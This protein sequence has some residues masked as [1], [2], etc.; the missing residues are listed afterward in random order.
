MHIRGVWPGVGLVC[1]LLLPPVALAQWQID[2]V[3]PAENFYRPLEPYVLA[4]P[5]DLPLEVLR[6][7]SLELND[8]DVTA[9]VHREGDLAIFKPPQAMAYGT[10]HLRLVESLPD[11]SIVERALWQVEVR[12]SRALREASLQGHADLTSARRPD[13]K[14]V[15][16]QLSANQRQGSMS[17]DG[18]MAND[19]WRLHATADVIHNS[20]VDQ[21]PND[22]RTDLARGLI[23]ADRGALSLR[24]GDHAIPATGLVMRDFARRGISGSV[25]NDGLRA[26][27]TAFAMR[28]ETITGFRH[29]LGAGDSANRSDG[30]MLTTQ[31]LTNRPE[32]LR[33]SAL[34]LNAEGSPVGDATAGDPES[35]RNDAAALAVDSLIFDQRLRLRGEY[36]RSD[37]DFDGA[38]TLVGDRSDKARSLLAQYQHPQR[39]LRGAVFGWNIG[40]EHSEVGP[41]F[42]SLANP[43]LPA[44]KRLDRV[45]S[46]LTWRGLS[47]N[48]QAA[49][50]TDNVDDEPLLPRLR[51]DYLTL[52]GTYTP[53]RQP[54]ETG[55]GRLFN[56]PSLAF[57]AQRMA[58]KHT[59]VPAA[60]GGH[61]VDQDTD[62]LHAGARFSPGNW[63][64]DIAH[65]RT[66]FDDT[67]GLQADYTNDLTE[68]GV[69]LLLSGRVSLSPRIQYNRF[70]DSTHGL[71]TRTLTAML[72]ASAA[73]IPGKLD[74]SLN[75]ALNRERADDDSLDND[76][77]SVDALLNWT[78][79]QPRENRP[80]LSVYASGSYFDARKAPGATPDIYQIFAGLRIGWPVAY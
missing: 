31:P 15:A 4:L 29:G 19:D 62:L 67:A 39:E 6:R 21:M 50:E 59:D 51:T 54:A 2:L 35:V 69:D 71:V 55:V 73:L 36:A 34:Y 48:A 12:Q 14:N 42:Y 27:L 52:G 72:G 63:S 45:F 33:V 74:A 80:G 57:S 23:A 11:G 47:L 56:G 26:E 43:A 68:F 10:H 38:G 66:W 53:F 8:I 41:W 49:R 16:P 32:R 30:V 22:R 60:F 79:I 76:S 40:A 17:L 9:F 1:A 46:G 78:L 65:T 58:Q 20:Q 61:T 18:R 37:T 13:D 3:E 75:Y 24:A 28:T 25:R 5:P 64:W 44:D 7:L 70:D 77:Y